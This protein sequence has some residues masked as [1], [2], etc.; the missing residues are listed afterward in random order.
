MNHKI[1]INKSKQYKVTITQTKVYN[2][3][4]EAQN[5]EYVETIAQLS[6]LSDQGKV[7][8]EYIDVKE[9]K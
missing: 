4:I 6:I 8:D 2:L 9:I 5:R 1:R 3:T 7:I